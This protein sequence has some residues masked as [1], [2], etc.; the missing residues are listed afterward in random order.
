MESRGFT[1]VPRV[2]AVDRDRDA[3]LL[4]WAE[5][6]LVRDGVGE[7]EISQACDFLR[8]LHTLRGSPAVPPDHLAAEACLSVIEIERQ[9]R[10]RIASLRSL[11]ETVADCF[12]DEQAEPE[13]VDTPGPRASG[14]RGRGGREAMS[15]CPSP[16]AAR[17]RPIS[18]FTTRS[19]APMGG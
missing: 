5:G 2:I 10:S 7:A 17:C 18:A 19:A 9:L 4:S 14:D 6:D 3:V 11:N 16:A 12:L 13:M 8:Q 1:M 15:I